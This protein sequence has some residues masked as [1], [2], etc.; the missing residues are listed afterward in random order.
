MLETLKSWD[1]CFVHVP[2][3]NTN[4][5]KG[6]ITYYKKHRIIVLKKHEDANHVIIVKK[7]G[8]KWSNKNCF[9]KTTNKEKA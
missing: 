4:E 5:M 3:P 6:L 7:N 8:G 2:N 1:V 9:W